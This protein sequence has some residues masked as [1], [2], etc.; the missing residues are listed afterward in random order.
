MADTA[1]TTMVESASLLALLA[2]SSPAF[3]VGAF[4]YSAGLESAVEE[5][6]VADADDLESWIADLLSHGWMWNDAVL[7]RAS[8]AAFDDFETLQEVDALAAA[9]AGSAE[10][11]A[12]TVALGTSFRQASRAW[13]SPPALE[14]LREPTYPAAFG[15]IAGAHGL[16][17][18]ATLLAFLHAGVS[19]QVQ[20]AIRL[21][22]LGQE[23]GVS[24]LRRQE[25]LVRDTTARAAV[26]SLDDLGM[27]A[28]VADIAAMRH[29]TQTTR[30]FRS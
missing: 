10:R 2:W 3:P 15:A 4:A 12:E 21:G 22:V 26:A 28:F 14:A 19:A 17:L 1:T 29:E 23:R 13:R 5:S 20:A 11:W 25:T 27:A 30:L 6:V 9:L 7:A 24:I 16:A 8:H 18:H